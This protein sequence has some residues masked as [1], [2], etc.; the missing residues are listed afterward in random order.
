MNKVEA[1]HYY[2]QEV[3][4]IKEAGLFKGESPIVT[5]QSAHVK[6]EDGR[7][8]INMCANNYLGLGNDPRLIQA[9]QKSYEERATAWLLCGL[10]AVHRIVTNSWK[11]RYR[12]FW[13]W[14]IRSCIPP[15]SM[16][17]A[18][19]LKRFWGRRTR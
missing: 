3:K 16:P 1:L 19:C 18:V 13:A 15:A 4:D 9:A 10:S 2:A 11:Q 7:E 6:L 12:I 14:T 8:V 5:P 17:T